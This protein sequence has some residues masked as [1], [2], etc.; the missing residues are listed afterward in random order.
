M[1]DPGPG[2]RELLFGS[3][4]DDLHVRLGHLL[5][6]LPVHDVPAAAIKKAA[7]IVE[8]AAQVDVGNVYMPVFVG[9]QRL[10]ETGPFEGLLAVPLLQQACLL[11]NPIRAGGADGDD[12]LVEHHE[13]QPT[14]SFER[15]IKVEPDDLLMLPV[16]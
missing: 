2:L 14:I 12:V 13:G 1:T 8:G 16:F 11:Q 7:Q 5:P 3:L 4:E 9:L 15:M 10:D 6:G